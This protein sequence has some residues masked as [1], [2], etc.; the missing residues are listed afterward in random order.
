MNCESASIDCGKDNL[1]FGM[2]GARLSSKRAVISGERQLIL[3]CGVH[4]MVDY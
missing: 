2:I 4:E 1:V 3:N